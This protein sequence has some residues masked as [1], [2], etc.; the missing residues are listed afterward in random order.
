MVRS[1]P[2]SAGERFDPC[3]GKIPHATEQLGPFATTVE[4]VL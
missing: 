3:F 4:P 1:S 2:A